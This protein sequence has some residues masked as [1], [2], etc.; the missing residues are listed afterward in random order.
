MGMNMNIHKKATKKYICKLHRFIKYSMNDFIC[1]ENK[2]NTIIYS[3]YDDTIQICISYTKNIIDS[4]DKKVFTINITTL[5]NHTCIEVL[6]HKSNTS[7]QL[8][9]TFIEYINNCSSYIFSKLFD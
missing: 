3:K 1:I 8:Y 2:N 5:D 7:K 4:S 6:H 9:K